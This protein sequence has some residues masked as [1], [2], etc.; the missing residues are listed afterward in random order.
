MCA[1]SL[2][3]MATLLTLL[4]RCCGDPGAPVVPLI[5]QNSREDTTQQQHTAGQIIVPTFLF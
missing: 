5:A 2:V 4:C 3:A 1:S